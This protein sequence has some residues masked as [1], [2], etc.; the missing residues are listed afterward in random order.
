MQTN[1]A[2]RFNSVLRIPTACLASLGM[3][4]QFG[5]C[6]TFRSSAVIAKPVRRLVVAIRII[7]TIATYQC[8]I[9]CEGD[10][11]LHIFNQEYIPQYLLF[12][13]LGQRIPTACFASL[14]MTAQF[15]RCSNF[16]PSAVIAK[17]VRRLVVAIRIP[18]SKIAKY[19]CIIKMRG[20]S[21]PSHF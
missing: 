18:R 8:I 19:K 2:G 7:S 20:R 15:G 14:G 3:T 4:A 10:Q 13:S 9:K 21:M 1:L 11:C 5:R 6:S 17:P 16:P 12:C